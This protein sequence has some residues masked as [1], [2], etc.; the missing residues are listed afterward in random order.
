M[1]KYYLGLLSLIILDRFL[2]IFF[3]KTLSGGDGVFSLYLNKNIAFSLPVPALVL[4]PMLFL[5]LF[6][7][8]FVWYRD[9]RSEKKHIW[10][11]GLIIIGAASNIW[12]RLQYGGVID[13]FN[14]P[15]FTVFNLSDV[16][17]FLGVCYFLLR[18]LKN[19]P[20]SSPPKLGGD[21][22]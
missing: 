21:V 19:T 3:L 9:F 2:K 7:L 12:D 5:I 16:Y 4:Y 15:F 13:Y 17:I 14:V 11:Y 6:I 10:P 8:I 20:S 18:Q 1:L 22:R